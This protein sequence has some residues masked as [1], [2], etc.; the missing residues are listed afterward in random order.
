MVFS[1]GGTITSSGAPGVTRLYR[2]GNLSMEQFCNSIPGLND[3][4]DLQFE[5]PF[6]V[7]SYDITITNWMMLANRINELAEADLVDGF[8]ISQGTDTLEETAYFLTLTAKTDKPIVLSA[9]MRPATS[10][11]SDGPLNFYQAV[12]LAASDKARGHGALVTFA[13]GIFSARDAQK[14]HRFRAQAFSGGDFGMLGYMR[15]ET[16]CF[17]HNTE[18]RHTLQTE[19][20]IRGL[21]TLPK[22]GLAYYYTEAESEILDIVASNAAGLVIAGSP[23]GSFGS[24]WK[25]KVH[26]LTKNGLIVLRSSRVADGVLM[27]DNIDN[28]TG[29]IPSGTLSPQKARILLML[30]L[31]KTNNPTEV[32]RMLEVY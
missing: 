15:D 18:K 13:D 12:A 5:E 11:S 24:N 6:R 8:V 14:V 4:A 22:V 2:D 31:T 17:F 16:V 26:T 30:A 29:T 20:D 23:C 10:L 7:P 28:D 27:D 32:R 19:F 3:L 21:A 1:T 9:A 25:P